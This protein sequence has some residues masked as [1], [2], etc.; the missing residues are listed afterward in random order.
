[1]VDNQCFTI[2]RNIFSIDYKNN[3]KSYPLLFKL[4]ILTIL[5]FCNMFELPNPLKKE[6]AFRIYE[7]AFNMFI[8]H[9]KINSRITYRKS[10]KLFQRQF[11]QFFDA[12]YP[13]LLSQYF[14]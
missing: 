11:Y 9:F 7:K 6:K 3:A 14:I 8:R 1:M 2:L 10:R 5:F 12:R 4:K 13:R